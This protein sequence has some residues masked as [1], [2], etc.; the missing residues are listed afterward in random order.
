MTLAGAQSI[1]AFWGWWSAEGATTIASSLATGDYAHVPRM[2]SARTAL[3]DPEL[4]WELGGGTGS[5]HR[6][7]VT[8]GGLSTLRPLA[9]RW[10]RA[11]PASCETWQ[12]A[13]A[14]ERVPHPAAKSVEIGGHRFVLA[15]SRWSLRLDER[16]SCVDVGIW[17]PAF[18]ALSPADRDTVGFLFLDWMLGE[19][20]VERWVGEVDFDTVPGSTPAFPHT[21][22]LQA[23]E[24]LAATAGGHTWVMLRSRTAI[25]MPVLAT[26]R[27]PLRWID[28]PDFDLHNAVRV[29]YLDL[30]AEGLPGPTALEWLRQFEDALLGSLGT[31]AVLLASETA[32]GHRTLFLHTDSEDAASADFIRRFAQANGASVQQQLD[33]RWT[34]L[35]RFS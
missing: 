1:S 27:R 3:I 17:H 20:G 11:A 34:K 33:P 28:R 31:K 23:V 22:L 4:E 15:D 5:L 21:S 7:T 13:A 19:D 12:F 8:A 25:G 24:H 2:L 26:A 32:E 35:K 14:R 6:L 29:A 18:A 9:E 10:R 30:T 16:R